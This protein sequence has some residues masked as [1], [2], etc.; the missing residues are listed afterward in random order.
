VTVPI[1]AFL[2]VSLLIGVHASRRIGG[3][4]RNFYV[5][6]NTFPAWVLTVSLVGQA[7]D[8]TGS[9]GT[10]SAALTGTAWAGL[11]LPAG[12]GVSLVLI[13]LFYAEPLHRE[14]LL[15]LPD[16][17]YR[18]YGSTVECMAATLCVVSFIVLLASNLAAVGIVMNAM[19]GVGVV[20]AI[21]V[22]SAVVA[23]YTMAGGLF[24]ATWNDIPQVSVKLL[25]FGAALVWMLNAHPPEVLIAAAAPAVAWAPLYDMHQ[26]ALRNWASFLALGLGDIVALDFMERVFAAKSPRHARVACLVS[27][28]STIALGVALAGLGAMARLYPPDPAA[29]QPF[30]DF[31]RHRLPAGIGMM[32]FM[33]LVSACIAMLDGV[34]MACTT[35]ITR[36]ILQR[37]VPRLIPRE[38]LLPVSRMVALPVAA[39]AILVA[40]IRPAPG[41]LLVLAFDA[42]FAGC[43]VPLTLGIYWRRANARA[44]LWSIA[45]PSV[46]RLVL[47]VVV[48]DRW[49]GID[50]LAPP[51]LSL[52]L[53][54]GITRW[55]PAGERLAG[56][57]AR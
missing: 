10:A 28:G 1:F 46:L 2:A 49:T 22:V 57:R 11:A 55:S 18:R 53:F 32:V 3:K 8:A 38:R 21:I 20:W 42:V 5:A 36:N 51:V 4:V 16:F 34:L 54:V 52:L 39:L 47:Y 12:I 48:P 30:L 26:Q 17:Y 6:G 41:D 23:T 13:G 43:L 31:V 33:A 25:G 44:A 29:A 35:V 9:L 37:H 24:A 56:T 45:A 50:T 15:T 40:V 7:V 27:G 19:L 14:R